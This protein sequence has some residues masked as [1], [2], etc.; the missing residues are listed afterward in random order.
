MRDFEDVDDEVRQLI[1]RLNEVG[2]HTD[3]S[4][5]GGEGH[6]L[7]RPTV[8]ARTSAGFAITEQTARRFAAEQERIERV[9]EEMG[10]ADFWLSLVFARGR[11]NTHG[12]EPTWLIQVPGRFD[13]LAL[14]AA[15][16]AEYVD[17][18][19]DLIRPVEEVRARGYQRAG[20]VF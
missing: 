3:W 8:Q 6:M 18:D 15:Y 1:V 16:S 7:I 4:C 12:G 14:P 19:E 11:L 13:S 10:V 5:D 20:S 17:A 9:L 2:I